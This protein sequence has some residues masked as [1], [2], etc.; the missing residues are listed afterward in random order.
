LGGTEALRMSSMVLYGVAA[1]VKQMMRY[2][3]VADPGKPLPVELDLFA[4]DQLI[5]VERGLNR[6]DGEAVR[7]G[8]LVDVIGGN[9]GRHARH[10]L[11]DDIGS[12]GNML[13]DELG[14]HA[15]VEIVD[16]AGRRARYQPDG[17]ALIKGGLS[18]KAKWPKQDQE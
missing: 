1:H 7:L 4:A 10:V 17:F 14:N 11:H 3:G 16:A 2:G 15:R 8:Y 6:A 18:V 5:E 9:H 13:R 12:A